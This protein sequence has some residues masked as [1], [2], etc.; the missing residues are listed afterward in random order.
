M[1]GTCQQQLCRTLV[2]SEEMVG[3][4]VDCYNHFNANINQSL[5]VLCGKYSEELDSVLCFVHDLPL[6][7]IK[8][9]HWA[10]ERCWAGRFFYEQF[11]CFE[12]GLNVF[13]VMQED[14]DTLGRIP[15]ESAAG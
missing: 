9:N 7:F 10:C 14:Y 8:C 2:T 15:S 13:A 11:D 6:A 1:A 3:F 4:C 5:C 12:C